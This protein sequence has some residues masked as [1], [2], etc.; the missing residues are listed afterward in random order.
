MRCRPHPKSLLLAVSVGVVL[1]G[2]S[3]ERITAAPLG[4]HTTPQRVSIT[5]GDVLY[6]LDGKI[7]DRAASDTLALIPSEIRALAP[8][9]VKQIEVLKGEA[10]RKRYGAAGEN[11]VVLITTKRRD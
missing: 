8:D 6:I 4:V 10:A 5:S 3:A 7:L 1:A 11:G 2:C 9:D